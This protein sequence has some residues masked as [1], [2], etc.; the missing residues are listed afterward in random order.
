MYTDYPIHIGAI[1]E[2]YKNEQRLL[3]IG[4]TPE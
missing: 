1:Y 2:L 4:Q 3:F